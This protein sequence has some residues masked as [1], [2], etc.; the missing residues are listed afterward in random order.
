MGGIPQRLALL[1][2]DVAPEG[3]QKPQDQR[4]KETHGD[5][6]SSKNTVRFHPVLAHDVRWSGAPKTL[7]FAGQH[8]FHLFKL[9]DGPR[10]DPEGR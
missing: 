2:L 8:F 6:H 9:P 5:G 4:S 7:N 3:S 10:T 1:I